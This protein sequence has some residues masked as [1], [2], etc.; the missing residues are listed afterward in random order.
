VSTRRSKNIFSTWFKHVEQ[1]SEIL[2]EYTEVKHVDPDSRQ[3]GITAMPAVMR[4]G[5]NEKWM[6][7]VRQNN[8]PVLLSCNLVNDASADTSNREV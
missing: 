3:T 7:I 5:R 8:V 2:T 6:R 1:K 4:N